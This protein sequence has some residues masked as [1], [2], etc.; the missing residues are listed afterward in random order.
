VRTAF[1]LGSRLAPAFTEGRA[2]QLFITPR[3]RKGRT[4]T[5]LHAELLPERAMERR[6]GENE[7]AHPVLSTGRI[8]LWSWGRG[9]TVL[10]VHGW[11]GSAADLAPVAA[12]LVRAGYRAVLFDMPGHGDA[13]STPTNLFVYLRTL[14]ALAPLVGPLE[15]VVA[16][17]LGGTAIALALGQR[18]LSA[19]R[20]A[21]VAPA[22]SPWA[23]SWHF[24]KM[25]GLP[26]ERVP[27]MVARTEQLVGA[28]A[29]SLN[30]AEVVATLT[31]PAY[32]VHD[33]DDLDVPFEHATGLAAAWPGAKLVARPG[34]GHRRILRDPETVARIVGFV[35]GR[36]NDTSAPA[37]RRLQAPRT[38][39]VRERRL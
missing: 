37:P 21:L 11:S 29:D 9:P 14:E 7:P 36:V 2:A 35:G 4:P 22:L 31:T 3:L 38:G 15:G 13:S 10:L 24:A 17:S 19:K 6:A 26:A 20:A 33:P 28:S 18:L 32:L 30:A 1:G 34:L 8:A 25:I 27:G 39:R 16:H 5:E 23:F 12:E